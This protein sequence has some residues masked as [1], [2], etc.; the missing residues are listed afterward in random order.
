M[1]LKALLLAG[2]EL[3]K[4]FRSLFGNIYQNI[5][6]HEHKEIHNAYTSLGLFLQVYS[7]Q[8]NVENHMYNDVC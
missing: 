7:N 4:L 5:R 1:R 3:I 6:K 2:W 8:S